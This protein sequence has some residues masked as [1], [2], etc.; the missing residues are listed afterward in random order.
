MHLLAV[1]APFLAVVELPV[2]QV[3]RFL[4]H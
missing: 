2:V 3:A 4:A 1:V